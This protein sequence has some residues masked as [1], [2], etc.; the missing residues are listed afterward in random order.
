[1]TAVSFTFIHPKIGPVTHDVVDLLSFTEHARS[2]E[3]TFTTPQIKDATQLR[4]ITVRTN[5]PYL[6]RTELS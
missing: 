3:A 4:T 6:L 5:G 1:M 2:V